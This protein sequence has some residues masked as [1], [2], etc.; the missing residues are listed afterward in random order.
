MYRGLLCVS[1]PKLVRTRPADAQG[2][3]V[4]VSQRPLSSDRHSACAGGRSDTL[5]SLGDLQSVAIGPIRSHAQPRSCCQRICSDG[6]A[7]GGTYACDC[8][9]TPLGDNRPAIGTGQECDQYPY[10]LY[11][12]SIV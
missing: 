11:V 9:A 1:R 12:V 10:V 4:G 6:A 5:E 7:C 3:D 8:P 2:L